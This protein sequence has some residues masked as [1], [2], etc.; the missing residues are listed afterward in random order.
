[1]RR[2]RRS[3]QGPPTKAYAQRFVGEAEHREGRRWQAGVRQVVF[4]EETTTI[5][6]PGRD[7]GIGRRAGLKIRC[8]QGR[9]GSSPIPGTEF[10]SR[11]TIVSESPY[12]HQVRQ[13]FLQWSGN[14]DSYRI[15]RAELACSL[16]FPELVSGSFIEM[17]DAKV[18]RNQA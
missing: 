15:Q 3:S 4:A 14:L 16:A 11:F 10:L 17:W 6:I 9:M 18:V 1:M 7:G 12:S 13:Y 2:Q 8:P 5:D